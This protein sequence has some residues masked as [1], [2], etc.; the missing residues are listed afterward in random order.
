MVAD[1]LKDIHERRNGFTCG[2]PQAIN[3]V[4]VNALGENLKA[5]HDAWIA[6]YNSRVGP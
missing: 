3:D 4:T 6:I 2:K 1:P 5:E